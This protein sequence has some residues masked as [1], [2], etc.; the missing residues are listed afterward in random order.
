MFYDVA[1]IG[2][3]PAG[4]AAG[5]SLMQLAPQARVVLFEASGYD[6]WR[7]GEVLSGQARGLL[8]SLRCWEQLA[9]TGLLPCHGNRAAWGSAEPHDNEFIFSLHGSSWRLDRRR[10]DRTLCE[11]A[12]AAGV[13]VLTRARVTESSETADGAWSLGV[14]SGRIQAGFVIDASGRHSCFASRRGA[15]RLAADHLAGVALTFEFPEH[16]APLDNFTWIE[17]QVDGWWYSSIVPGGRAQV[18]VVAWMSDTDLIRQS[19]LHQRDQ[20]LAKL[21]STALTRERVT[22]ASP[23]GRP[24]VFSARSQRLSRFAGPR[25]AAAG[26]AAMAFDP[27]SS[28]GIFAALRTGKLAGFVACDYLQGKPPSHERYH[29]LLAAEYEGYLAARRLFYRMERRWAQSPF[30]QRRHGQW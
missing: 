25:W 11:C 26:D 14:P 1:I 22:H 6:T 7:H 15:K 17:A 23:V 24:A 19:R 28:Q 18:A 21:A 3:G 27:L 2:G 13:E 12:R 20:W 30:W 10:F 8:E 9:G 16:P 5:L 4:S 29:K